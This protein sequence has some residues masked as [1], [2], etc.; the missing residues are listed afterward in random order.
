ME[1]SCNTIINYDS[2]LLLILLKYEDPILFLKKLILICQLLIRK[3][4]VYKIT[5]L[6]SFF[7]ACLERL[8]LGNFKCSFPNFT[9]VIIYFLPFLLEKEL[10][11]ALFILL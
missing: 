2:S 10:N 5:H 9:S 1:K 4:L 7:L 3:I 8:K 11:K 6:N